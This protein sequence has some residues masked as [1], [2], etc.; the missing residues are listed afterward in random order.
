MPRAYLNYDEWLKSLPLPTHE[1]TARFAEHVADNHSW[2]KHL[3]FF[4]PGASF[5]FFLNPIAGR[6]VRREGDQFKVYDIDSGD[7][8]E[9]HSQLSTAEYVSRFG[10]W[11]YWVGENPRDYDRQ[12]GPWLYS[13]DG[14]GRELLAN[15]L[16]R[17]WSRRLTALLRPM[18]QMFD[19][20]RDEL[21]REAEEFL[22]AYNC[23][24]DGILLDL[25]KGHEDVARG[26]DVQRYRAVAEAFRQSSEHAFGPALLKF[27]RSE[28]RVQ[29]RSLLAT[30][31][32]VRAALF[33]IQNDL[34]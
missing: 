17:Q 6:G 16:K 9:H 5:V 32:L 33:E 11:D 20:R 22:T 3:P 24:A 23:P 10:Y 12:P 2:Y 18:P 19:L 28:A 27:M 21:K 4:P 25:S 8:F 13:L 34:D 26:S 30:L 7:Y 29:R 14:G 1:Q 31:Q 15:N